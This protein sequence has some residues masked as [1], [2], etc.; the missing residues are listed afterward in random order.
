M[1]ELR[2]FEVA[3]END[4][5]FQ[6]NSFKIVED[7][8]PDSLHRVKQETTLPL[9]IQAGPPGNNLPLPVNRSKEALSC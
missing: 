7:M 6:K 3:I 5:W 9:N 4:Q 2:V 8:P 1:E